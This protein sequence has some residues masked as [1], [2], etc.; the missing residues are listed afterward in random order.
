MNLQLAGKKVLVTGSTAGIGLA[1]A[2]AFY[3]EGAQVYVNGRTG[4]RVA[5]AI[6]EISAKLPSVTGGKV[7]G[8]AADLAIA[9]G[10]AKLFA[11][12]P[13]V[14]I[15]I[16]NLGIYEAKPAGDLTDEDWT[17][18][19]STNV[20]SGAR[21]SRHYLKAMRAREW[22]RVVFI[23]SESGVNIP[24]EMIHYGVSKSAQIALAR[25]L[26]ETTVG[27]AIT[28]NSVLP[29]PTYSE[30]INR[31]LSDVLPAGITDRKAAEVEFVKKL[32]PSSLIQRF[33]RA[34]E[35]ASLVVYLSS[36]LASSTNGAAVRVEGGINRGIL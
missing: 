29:G 12:L 35:V 8:V 24:A 30:G 26:A 16:N 33:S 19:L 15:L 21:L 1:I 34:E 10:A 23:A 25:G 22:G 5:E 18:M 32:R 13:E 6:R 17:T 2:Q 11:E 20:I 31:F 27:T 3:D 9:Q 7:T 4:P 28:V 14:D 36:P